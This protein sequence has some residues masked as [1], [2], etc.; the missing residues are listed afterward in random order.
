MR[1][2]R[3]R[4]DCD[5]GTSPQRRGPLTSPVD[6]ASK[7]N[8]RES[9]NHERWAETN[10]AP[11]RCGHRGSKPMRTPVSHEALATDGFVAA[12]QPLVRLMGED[13]SPQKYLGKPDDDIRDTADH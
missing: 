6:R 4:S 7:G 5:S 11:V 13:P 3:I 8:K 10:M 9:D 1:L 12:A 2:H